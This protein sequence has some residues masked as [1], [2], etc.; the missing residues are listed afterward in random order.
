MLNKSSDAKADY[1]GL[2][3]PSVSNAFMDADLKA[4]GVPPVFVINAFNDPKTPVDRCLMLY[5]ALQK[6][7]VRSELHVFGRGNHGF[8][9]GYGKG[10]A[11]S[12]WPQAF[13]AWLKDENILA[14]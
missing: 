4:S 1:L 2:F 9:L 10:H 8:D 3:Y 12:G 13:L 6:A 14:D 5:T 11:V 7:G